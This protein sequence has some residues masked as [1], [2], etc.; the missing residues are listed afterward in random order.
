MPKCPDRPAVRDRILALALQEF[1]RRG[2]G[3]AR[4]D[5]IARQSRVSKRMLFYY[6][7]NKEALFAEVLDSAWQKGRVVAEAPSAPLESVRFWREFYMRNEAWLRL[8]IWESLDPAP[9]GL[10]DEAE[11]RKIWDESVR[12]VAAASGPG[13]WP[14]DLKPEYLLIAGLGLIAGPLLLPTISRLTTGLDAHDPRFTAEYLR[15]LE[16]MISLITAHAPAPGGKVVARRGR[17][18]QKI[19]L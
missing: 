3:G 4:V 17:R 8:M 6:F 13:A 16:R 1:S 18:A 7:R 14:P 15:T 10:V 9:K 11:Q 5:R 12:K 19:A 2:Y